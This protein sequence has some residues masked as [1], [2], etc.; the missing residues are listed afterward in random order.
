MTSSSDFNL[1]RLEAPRTPLQITTGAASTDDV[2]EIAN[3]PSWIR[4]IAHEQEQP[5][6]DLQQLYELCGT[7]IDRADR[8]I[9]DIEWAYYTLSQGTRYVY[10]QI[11]S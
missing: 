8:Q 11:Q 10:D 1:L 7:T 9:H 2:A 5:E 4:A 3:P 6:H